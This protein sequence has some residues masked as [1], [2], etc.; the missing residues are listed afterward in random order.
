MLINVLFLADSECST[1]KWKLAPVLLNFGTFVAK[2]SKGSTDLPLFVCV[3]TRKNEVDKCSTI[4][5]IDG[6]CST[7]NV[8]HILHK[9]ANVLPKFQSF[10]I[11]LA[12]VLP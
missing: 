2:V 9:M 4:S 8:L 1:K 11:M 7:M 6:W 3:L 5:N 10:Y 12:C